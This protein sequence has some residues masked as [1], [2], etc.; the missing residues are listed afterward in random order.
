MDLQKIFEACANYTGY[1]RGERICEPWW[2]HA[3]AEQHLKSTLKDILLAAWQR[4][5]RESGKLGVGEGGEEES[6]S[7]C[8]G[9]GVEE[10]RFFGM[11]GRRRVTLGW[12]DDPVK[13]QDVRHGWGGRA[14]DRRRIGWVG[15]NK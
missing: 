15:S 3:A 6:V 8:D 14:S 13:N 10:Q 1:E 11:L 7:G 4:R 2:R 12:A 5:K 9:L